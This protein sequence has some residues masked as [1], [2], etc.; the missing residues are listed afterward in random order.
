MPFYFGDYLADTGHL[1]TLEHGAYLLLIAHYWQKQGLPN[2]DAQLARIARLTSAQWSRAR[3]VLMAFFSEGWKHKRIEFEL[4]EAARISEA[5]RKGGKASAEARANS[6]PLKNIE[7][8]PTMV[9]RQLND[10]TN[11]SLT[12]GQALQSQPQLQKKERK[13]ETGKMLL[14]DDWVV[15]PSHYEI[16]S[17]KNLT[18]SEVEEAAAEM[19][20]WSLGNGERRANWDWVFNNW[21]GRNAE[22][23]GK[24]NGFGGPRPL[25]DD[26]RSASR[27]AGRLAEAAERGEFSFGPRPSLLPEANPTV[28]ELL[29]QRRGS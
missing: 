26:S 17:K 4:T 12:N 3:P 29:P 2:D 8:E 1:T 10:H 21:L 27:A 23:K 16:G 25:Q 5:G 11:D 20:A 13:K 9:Q 15:K 19:R 6:K 18:S 7:P 14:P 28:V 22:R 24:R